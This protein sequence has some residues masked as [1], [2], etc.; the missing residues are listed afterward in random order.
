MLFQVLLLD[1]AN[2]VINLLHTFQLRVFKHKQCTLSAYIK[3]NFFILSENV[4]T[5]I[6][7]SFIS[8]DN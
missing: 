2:V 5:Q 6:Q 3:N 8:F 4:M 1:V 7:T